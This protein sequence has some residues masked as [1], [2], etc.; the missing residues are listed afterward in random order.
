M[1]YV[2]IIICIIL[3]IIQ[4]LMHKKNMKDSS[5]KILGDLDY[6][7]GLFF[8]K[9]EEIKA[10]IDT[11]T[12]EK[13]GSH[14]E[15]MMKLQDLHAEIGEIASIYNRPKRA[16]KEKVEE[17]ITIPIKDVNTKL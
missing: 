5:K 6:N 1:E 14:V 8:T 12:K 9:I 15:I 4:D 11:H 17:K 13:L 2:L 16:K 7:Y 10:I 3:L